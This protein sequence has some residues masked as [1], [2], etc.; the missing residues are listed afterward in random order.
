MGEP[1]RVNAA[2]LSAAA[3]CATAAALGWWVLRRE[4]STL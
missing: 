2:L 3:L 1:D 4:I